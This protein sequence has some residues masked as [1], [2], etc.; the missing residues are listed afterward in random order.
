[1]AP[2]EREE[3][4]KIL[5]PTIHIKVHRQGKEMGQSFAR[6]PG[7]KVFRGFLWDFLAEGYGHQRKSQKL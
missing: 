5:A 1:L 7:A 4:K 6:C 3:E 2:G